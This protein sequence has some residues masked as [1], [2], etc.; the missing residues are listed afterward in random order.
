VKQQASDG[1]LGV[2]VSG[3]GS[4]LKAILEARLPVVVVAADRPCRGLEV[5]AAAGIPTRLVDRRAFGGF[6]DRFDRQR[7][8][9][10]LLAELEP[11][12]LDL[13]AMAGF[14][15]VLA[16]SFFQAFGERVVNTHPSLLPAF[17]GWHAVA[18]ALAAGVRVT[19]CTV[20][21]ATPAL[22]AGPVLAQEE[23]PVLPGDTEEQLHERI[24]QV[25]RRLYPETIRKVLAAC[26]LRAG[27]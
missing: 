21:V 26:T 10:A 23:V 15:T 8:T 3:T 5:A 19:G 6:G 27:R 22:D 24:K 18:E 14:G 1:R 9:D 17:P 11:F 4:I 13:V 12:E 7:F 25:E 16:A 2:L 20:H